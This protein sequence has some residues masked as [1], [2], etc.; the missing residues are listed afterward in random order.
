MILWGLD[1]VLWGKEMVLAIKNNAN[2]LFAFLCD[3]SSSCF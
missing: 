1:F 3:Q 2:E